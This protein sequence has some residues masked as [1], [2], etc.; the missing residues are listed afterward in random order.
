MWF[1]QAEVMNPALAGAAVVV[2]LAAAA[3]WLPPTALCDLEVLTML[4]EHLGRQ[5]MQVDITATYCTQG[6]TLAQSLLKR[7]ESERGSARTGAGL[8]KL[9]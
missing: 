6:C 1:A 2:T 7:A 4:L 9:T 3:E 5:G 8:P